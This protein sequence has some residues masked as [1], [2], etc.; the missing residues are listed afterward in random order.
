MA[1]GLLYAALA[2]LTRPFTV[3]ADVV[4]AIPLVVVL[5]LALVTHLR[6]TTS[7][8]R[9]PSAIRSR[10]TSVW[11]AVLGVTA[12]WELYCYVNQPRQVH[13]TLSVLIDLL[14]RTHVGKTAAFAAWLAL[15]WFLARR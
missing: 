11:L 3:P 12:A 10:G 15:G 2:S 7:V 5:A 4:T 6:R 13:P 1:G 8:P 9:A 14:D